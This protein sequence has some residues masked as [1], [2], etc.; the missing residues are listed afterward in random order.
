MSI[1]EFQTPQEFLSCTGDFL[2]SQEDVNGLPLGIALSLAATPV[3]EP[4]LAAVTKGNQVRL[5]LVMN[6]DYLVLAGTEEWPREIA[7]AAV[8]LKKQGRHL[9]GVVGPRETALLFARMW[10]PYPPFQVE[11]EQRIYRL[12]TVSPLPLSPGRMRLATEADTNLVS[13]W[14]EE[15]CQ[16]ALKGISRE[17]AAAMAEKG[18]ANS[19]IYLWQH[20]QAVSMV[21]KARPTV[22]GIAL[23]LVYTPQEQRKKGY[24]TSCVASLCRLLLADKYKFCCLYTDLANP[25]SNKIYMDIGFVPV[26]DSL[27]I[28]FS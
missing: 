25:T 26:A 21:K 1:Q 4:L 18:I 13:L 9:A 6:T 2:L 14:I 8:Y 28:R 15:F 3:E 5:V 16:E 17:Q 12:E 19:S 10:Q 24:A 27:S 11:M 20:G 7:A 23:N 22:N